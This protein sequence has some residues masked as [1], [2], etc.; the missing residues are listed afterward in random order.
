MFAGMQFCPHC[1]AKGERVLDESAPSIACPGC[2]GDM[3]AVRVGA[4]AFHECASCAASWLSADTFSQLCTSHEERSAMM[5]RVAPDVASGVRTVGAAVRYVACPVCKKTM[6]RQ[7]F[8]RRSGVIIDVCKSH[9]V[10]FEQRELQSV[11]AFVDSGAFEQ[12]RREE[13]ERQA[14][15]RHKLELE[16]KQASLESIRLERGDM[17]RHEADTLLHDALKSLFS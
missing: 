17:S 9:G 13:I 15:A 2:H 8:G 6:N 16:F 4:T 1:G 7:N 5:G 11:L 12:S 3:L 14:E 10:W